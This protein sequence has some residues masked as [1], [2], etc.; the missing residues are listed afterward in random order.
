MIW[1]RTIVAITQSLE[2]YITHAK[3]LEKSVTD[4]AQSFE[5]AQATIKTMART[6]TLEK[7]VTDL[8]QSLEQAQATIKTMEAKQKMKSKKEK[9]KEAI[10]TFWGASQPFSIG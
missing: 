9:K 2:Q 5:Q 10:R 8:A 4:L 6:K 3:T 7:S 1:Q